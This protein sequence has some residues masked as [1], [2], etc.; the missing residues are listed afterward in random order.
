M[1]LDINYLSSL[2]KII[3]LDKKYALIYRSVFNHGSTT[4]TN[5]TKDTKVPK[6]TCYD[7]LHKLEKLG[8]ISTFEN[9]KIVFYSAEDLEVIVNIVKKERL[10]LL[11]NINV[12]KE[13]IRKSKTNKHKETKV[14]YF[15]NADEL[16]QAY[17]KTLSSSE[18]IRAYA[19]IEEMHKGLPNFFPEYYQRRSRNFIFINTISPDNLLSTQ[20]KQFDKEELREIKLIKHQSYNFTPEINIFDDK[21]LFAS[22]VENI[23]I[24]IESEKIASPLKSIFDYIFENIPSS[25]EAV[26]D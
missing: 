20:R 21:V 3:N 24:I 14:K 18:K 26:E 23:A 25:V 12:A 2:F 7:C 15:K 9:N 4:V 19:N 16:I 6:T 8:I 22:W 10:K 13:I 5:I 11:K 17:E 1:E